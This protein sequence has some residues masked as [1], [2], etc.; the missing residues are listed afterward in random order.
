MIEKAQKSSKIGETLE[1]LEKG[2]NSKEKESTLEYLDRSDD[3][4]IRE[5]YSIN[6]HKISAQKGKEV[7]S[8]FKASDVRIY[9]PETDQLSIKELHKMAKDIID[10]RSKQAGK[11]LG[12]VYAIHYRPDGSNKH[13][14]IA[15]FGDEKSLKKS[16]RGKEWI[17]K[18]DEIEL[19][20]TKDEKE[21]EKSN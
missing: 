4:Q 14:H 17:N 10:A 19:K 3:N 12:A 5:L 1:Y 6:G 21:R 16:G 7:A 11:K 2:K 9:N 18:L 20:Y 8:F 13:I 15:F